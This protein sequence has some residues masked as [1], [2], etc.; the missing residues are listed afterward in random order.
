MEK[1]RIFIS[2]TIYDFKDLRSSLRYWL[3][4]LGYDVQLSEYSDFDKNSSKNSYDAC[5]EAISECSIFILLIGSRVG[6][7]YDSTI[8]ITRKEYQTA[9]EL[10]KVGKI[11]KII[12]FIRQNVWD[13]LEDRK[14]LR[15]L[16]CDEYKMEN[17]KLPG[18]DIANYNSK[19]LNDNAIHINSF[20]DEVL[21]K[22]EWNNGKK[23]LFNWVHQFNE[24]SD[25]VNTLR[26]EFEI[27]VSISEQIAEQNVK[28]AVIN[29]LQCFFYKEDGKISE[30]FKSLAPIYERAFSLKNYDSDTQIFINKNESR[31]IYMFFVSCGKGINKL[32]TIVF[33]D[34]ISNGIFSKYDKS[35]DAFVFNDLHNSLIEI[36]DEIKSLKTLASSNHDKQTK[37]AGLMLGF[38]KSSSD[39]F[40]CNFFDIIEFLGMYQHMNNI[41]NLSKYII[42]YIDSGGEN[43]KPPIL[44]RGKVG[45]TRPSK[46]EILWI[47]QNWK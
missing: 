18:Y 10:A 14:S 27:K 44:L 4:E 43:N 23:P 30:Y 6:G 17:S 26:A 37:C 13:V 47:L 41:V 33:D 11:K 31:G 21:R 28:L 45:D 2:S 24:F 8:S 25:I 46:D 38:E 34:A 3:N 39:K 22:E 35:K 20:V 42:E 9:Y 19:I 36:T 12:I 32:A 5:L 1:L 29:N 7:M 16:L 15:K 40:S